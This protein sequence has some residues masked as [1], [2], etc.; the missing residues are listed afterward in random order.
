MSAITAQNLTDYLTAQ[1]DFM[2]SVQGT[3]SEATYAHV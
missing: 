1:D 2:L 3:C